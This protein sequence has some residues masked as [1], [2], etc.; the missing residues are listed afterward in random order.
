M[1]LV[2]RTLTAAVL[3]GA[4]FVMIQYAPDWAFFIFGV[5]FASAAVVEFYN[6]TG[7]KELRAR[8]A[9]GTG[10]A[11]LVLLPSYFRAIPLDAALFA[12]ILLA[13]VYYLVT[14]NT[15]E[16]LPGFPG[17]FAVTL[18]GVLYVAFTLGFLFR[19]RLEE[20]PFYLY[21]LFGV[22]FLGDTGAFFI[23][24]PFG[25]HKMTP[26]ASPNKSWEGSLGGFLFA[27][28]AALLA[29]A[30]LFPHLPAGTAVLTALVVHAAAQVA[31]PLESLFK[32][33]VGVK[34]SSNSLPGHGGFLDRID[35]LILAGPLFYFI[36]RYVWK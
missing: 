36:V 3:L 10:L 4:I 27:V 8:K 1:N 6:L 12:A 11:V 24:K 13:G 30:I 20:G 32:R 17:S 2:K 21:F 35:S 25:R 31:D 23:G 9:L 16:K 19:I 14:V 34:D 28:G 15:Q 22:V 7:Q 29:R 5:I 18:T 33:A 26:V